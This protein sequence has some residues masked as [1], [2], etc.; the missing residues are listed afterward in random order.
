MIAV[1][2][3]GAYEKRMVFETRPSMV[4]VSVVAAC[5]R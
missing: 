4:I 1:T 3:G 5:S 2:L